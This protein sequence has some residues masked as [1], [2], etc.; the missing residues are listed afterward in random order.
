MAVYFDDWTIYS[1]LKEHFKWLRLMLEICRQIQLSLNIKK[2]IFSTPIGILLEHVECK[3]GIKVDLAK[4]KVIL[5]LKPLV[6]LNKLE[7]S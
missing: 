5:D 2:C 7:P 3:D 4:I 1:L 6:I